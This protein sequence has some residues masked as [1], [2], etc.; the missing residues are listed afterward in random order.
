LGTLA[1]KA[2]NLDTLPEV[3]GIYVTL[4]TVDPALLSRRANRVKMNLG[5][6]DPTSSDTDVLRRRWLPVDLDPVRLWRI[7]DR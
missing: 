6:K 2:A 1:D 3:P 7:L 4:N 5:R